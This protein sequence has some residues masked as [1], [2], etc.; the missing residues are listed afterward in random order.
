VHG[1]ADRLQ[2]IVWNLLS[3]AVKFTPRGGMVQVV[4]TRDDSQANVIVSDTGVGI[5]RDFI[6]HVFERFRQADAS[7]TRRFGGLGLGLGIVRHLTEL[8]GGTVR[9]QSEGEGQ[10]ATFT[11]A[12]PLAISHLHAGAER[13][14]APDRSSKP[15]SAPAGERADA[16]FLRGVR[17]LLAEDDPDARDLITRILHDRGARSPPPPAHRARSSPSATR[18]RTC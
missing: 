8:H 10:G 11:L 5:R 15:A 3:N 7:T 2:Q 9:V 4:L 13:S 17:V 1:D 14:G 6:P 18:A 12:L 16:Q